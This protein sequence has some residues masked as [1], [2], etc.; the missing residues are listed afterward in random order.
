M[1]SPSTQRLF[2][3]S[4]LRAF[5]TLL[6][7]IHHT[8]LAY[9]TIKPPRY[10][11]TGP[12]LPWAAFPIIDSVKWPGFDLLVGWNDIFFMALMFLVS[13]LFVWPGLKRHSAGMYI[14]RRLLRLGLPFVI[15]AGVLAPLAYYPAY[16][17]CGGEPRLSSYAS[18]WFTLSIWPAGPVWFLWVLFVFDC[19]AVISFKAIPR[20]VEA[21]AIR[22]CAVSKRPMLL[23]LML[24]T[25]SLVVY[26]PMSMRFGSLTWWSWE[27][28][29]VQAS[30]VLHYFVYFVM[31]VCLGA[32][33]T[34]TEFF[35]R[36]GKLARGWWLWC[37]RSAAMFTVTIVCVRF[38]IATG[39]RIGFAFSCA[40]SSLF[41]MA[42]VIRF[43][44][45]WRWADSLSANAYGIYLAHY[46]FVI[47]I[48]YAVLHWSAPA[49]VKGLA[50]SLA[51]VVMSW[52][53]VALMRRSKLIARVV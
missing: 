15:G 31:G 33:G 5:V 4:Y 52:M 19:I 47:W 34:E 46:V 38:G 37:I 45:P 21:M 23:F 7:V 2:Q 22:V 18:A 30:R 27:P 17:Q 53:T 25:I 39:G 6:V 10:S 50:V 20:A 49:F 40:A 9:M 14:R 3:L 13:G 8:L 42:L 26:A 1:Q 41:V 35:A 12:T 51:A 48:Q 36:T 28:F 16:L 32:F 44:R 29:A 24:G 43:A 11:F